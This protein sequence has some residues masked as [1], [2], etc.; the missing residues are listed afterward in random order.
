MGHPFDDMVLAAGAQL[1]ET[2][3]NPGLR[4]P[5]NNLHPQTDA[6]MFEI[7]LLKDRIAGLEKTNSEIVRWIKANSK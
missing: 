3:K 7:K 4:M 1:A 2:W 5:E 6:V